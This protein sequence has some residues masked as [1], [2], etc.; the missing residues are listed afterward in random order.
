[1]RDPRFGILAFIEFV[2]VYSLIV[3]NN[4]TMMT[5]CSRDI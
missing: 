5:V 2:H 3:S 4:Y 1:M